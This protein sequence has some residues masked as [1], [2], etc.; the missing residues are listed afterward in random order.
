MEWCSP[1]YSFARL[2]AA[3]ERC[4]GAG[5]HS[6]LRRDG[7]PRDGDDERLADDELD[8]AADAGAESRED[9]REVERRR[10]CWSREGA[11]EGVSGKVARDRFCRATVAVNEDGTIAAVGGGS[12]S[13]SAVVVERTT[14]AVTDSGDTED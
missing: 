4:R 1:P 7:E 3:G 13:R 12:S 5:H 2:T 14:S 10:S 9:N 6:S 8:D 11:L